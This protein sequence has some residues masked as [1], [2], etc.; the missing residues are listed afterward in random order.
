[1]ISRSRSAPTAFAIA[2]DNPAFL[3]ALNKA[4]DEV[5]KDGT[6]T[7]LQNQY[8]PGR[9]VPTGFRPGSGSVVFPALKAGTAS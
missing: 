5:I 4:L 8:Y 7:G 1:M 2:H 3:A 9:A 6:W